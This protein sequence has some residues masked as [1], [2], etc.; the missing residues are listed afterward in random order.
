MKG[1]PKKSKAKLAKTIPAIR[2]GNGS[3]SVRKKKAKDKAEQVVAS[4]V[5]TRMYRNILA[6]LDISDRL[7]LDMSSQEDRYGIEWHSLAQKIKEQYTAD[8]VKIV[9]RL[10]NMLMSKEGAQGLPKELYRNLLAFVDECLEFMKWI[11]SPASANPSSNPSDNPF[12]QTCQQFKKR[13]G[14]MQQHIC[15][16]ENERVASEESFFK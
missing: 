10:Q 4:K 7:T 3:D 5:R 6:L 9:P 12:M 13:C 15:I 16:F 8:V 11:R 14:E 1:I 2:M